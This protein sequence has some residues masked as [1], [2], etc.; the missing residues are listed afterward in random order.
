MKLFSVLWFALILAV[1][2]S[3]SS[4]S[5]KRKGNK[6]LRSIF[7]NDNEEE[8]D[9]KKFKRFD[10]D[11]LEEIR[12]AIDCNDYYLFMLYVSGYGPLILSSV[13]TNLLEY[14]YKD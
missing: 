14:I 11:L 4:G 5:C 2:C 7:N 13:E 10:D 6:S 8:F 9:H 3:S 1:Y 12:D